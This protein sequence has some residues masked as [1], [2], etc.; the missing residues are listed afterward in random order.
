MRCAPSSSVRAP[1]S[2]NS[3]TEALPV[4]IR[5]QCPQ[6]HPYR[7]D[8]GQRF[9]QRLHFLHPRPIS[10]F[11][12]SIRS[13]PPENRPL[14]LSSPTIRSRTHSNQK[15]TNLRSSLCQILFRSMGPS[16]SLRQGSRPSYG[17]VCQTGLLSVPDSYGI[18]Y[19]HQGEDRYGYY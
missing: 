19:L 6:T 2:Y 3:F 17:H 15:S 8:K 11:S 1:Y 10:P 4:A 9:H 12:F 18:A 7:R 13:P 16:R 14:H 5:L